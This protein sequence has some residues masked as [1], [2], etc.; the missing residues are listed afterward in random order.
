MSKNRPR[1]PKNAA[2]QIEPTGD[3]RI[4]VNTKNALLVGVGGA[5]DA[6]TYVAL[7]YYHP[8]H[9][10]FSEWQT[11]E[12][13][14]FSR[15]TVTLRST[16]PINVFQHRGLRCKYH[17][18]KPKAALPADLTGLSQDIEF[19]EMRVSGTAR[20]HGFMVESAFFLV[21]L[22]RQHTVFP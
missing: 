21:W 16:T 12:L 20:V 11:E 14:D 9:Q 1:V 19:M 6:P 10:C 18:G 5:K 22:D 2:R 7:K 13:K 3:G 15:Y 4:P 17:Q 8:A